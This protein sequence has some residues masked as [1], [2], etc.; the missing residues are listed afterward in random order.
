MSKKDI[1]PLLIPLKYKI[2]SEECLK[3]FSKI[4]KTKP[5]KFEYFSIES[6]NYNNKSLDN[7]EEN[8]ADYFS[9]ANIYSLQQI[10]EHEIIIRSHWLEFKKD[11]KNPILILQH[12]YFQYVYEQDI[13]KM[14][15]NKMATVL[16]EVLRDEVVTQNEKE[17]IFEKA[18]EYGV[19]QILLSNYLENIQ[20]LNP[21]FREII[22]RVCEDGVL[23]QNEKKYLIEK[24]SAYNVKKEEVFKEITSTL[25]LINE[26]HNL[27]ENE[28]FY[29]YL[30][31]LI[32]LKF[33]TNKF[34]DNYEQFYSR[35]LNS[36]DFTCKW[37]TNE[38]Y[39]LLEKT[40]LNLLKI[41]TGFDLF[42]NKSSLQPPMDIKT[43]ISIFGINIIPHSKF[44][45]EHCHIEH[46]EFSK[47]AIYGLFEN[48]N[49]EQINHLNKDISSGVTLGSIHYTF[50]SIEDLHMP[51]FSHITKG[52]SVEITLNKSH[53]FYSNDNK[54]KLQIIT[55]VSNIVKYSTEDDFVDELHALFNPPAKIKVNFQYE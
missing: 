28:L 1:H 12:D 33:L 19:D 5:I 16:R 41:K 53:Y 30:C 51:L 29:N 44:I 49:L 22:Y 3:H 23:T 27:I 47:G 35:I 13:L 2:S 50:E 54:L 46:K 45:D 48:A 7:I 34:E 21:A 25:N 4:D 9:C 20:V 55:I 6:Y 15:G 40:I 10:K 11:I 24:A 38:E 32:L 39:L 42:N 37:L 43:L 18:E 17:Y 52:N 36:Q 31:L 14:F 8:S 26:V